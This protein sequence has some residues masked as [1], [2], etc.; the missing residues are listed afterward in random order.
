MAGVDGSRTHQATLSRR[1]N[2]FEDRGAHRD[3][4][5][6]TSDKII[7]QIG[8]SVKVNKCHLARAALLCYNLGREEMTW[9][10]WFVYNGGG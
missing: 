2:G 6:P 7:L 1:R 9:M 10:A 5:T 3:S 4:T 8:R